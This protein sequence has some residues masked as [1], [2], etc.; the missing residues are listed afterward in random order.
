MLVTYYL[1]RSILSNLYVLPNVNYVLNHMKLPFLQ[2]KNDQRVA[3]S[4]GSLNPHTTIWV[5]YYYYLNLHS[6]KLRLREFN[7]CKAIKPVYGRA[8]IQTPTVLLQSL[9]SKT[10]LSAYTAYLYNLPNDLR[11]IHILTLQMRSMRHRR[12]TCP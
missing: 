2:V 9:L 7:L 4:Y 10:L 1:S 8:R 11:K 5:S 12:V 6:R 3:I